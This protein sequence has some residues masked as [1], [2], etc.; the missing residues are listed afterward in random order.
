MLNVRAVTKSFFG[1]QVLHGVDLE[2]REGEIHALIGENGAGKSTLVNIIAGIM[3]RDSGSMELKGEPVNFAHPLEAM[4]AGISMVHQE[5]SLVPNLSVAE[6][7]FLRHESKTALGFNDW[8]SMR[9]TAAKIFERMG[10]DIDPA[11]LVGSLSVG[12]QQLVEVAKAISFDAKL[13]IMD[14]PTS[15]LSEKET[16]ELFAVVRDLRAQGLSIVFISHKLSELFAISDRLTVLRDGHH[17]A[18]NDIA[19]ITADDVIRMMVGRHLGDLYPPKAAQMGG[20]VFECSGVSRFGYVRDLSFS[21]RRGEIVGF[22]GLVGSGRTEA[23]RAI[24]KADPRSSG[25]FKL[26]E[27]AVVWSDPGEAMDLG[28]VY[29]SEDRKGSGLF[30]DFNVGRNVAASTL[31]RYRNRFGLISRSALAE[32]A[33]TYVDMMDIRPPNIDARAIELSGGN[34][35]KVLLAKALDC[36]PKMLIVDEPT[37]GVDVGAKALIHARLR[38]LANSGVG[39]IIVSSEMPE[40]IGMSD[41]ILVFRNGEIAA[42]LDNRL[43]QVTQ[44]MVMSYAAY[45]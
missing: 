13:L 9:Q 12:M 18:T 25:S 44:E 7:I 40:V 8:R 10:V 28:V 23:M 27:K 34:Q 11:V 39:V 35:Q 3:R 32:K 24:I 16:A 2:V 4:R 21:V 38:D 22:A 42:E 37:R 45:K 36:R 20:T 19:Q 41:R 1:N 26:E 29:V 31:K 43:G 14:E 17:I 15:S 5:L 30:L 33:R 6:N